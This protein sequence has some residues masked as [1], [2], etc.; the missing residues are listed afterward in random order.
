MKYKTPK[1]NQIWFGFY[2]N[3]NQILLE[4]HLLE[5]KMT[6]EHLAKSIKNFNHNK[7]IKRILKKFLVTNYTLAK[8]KVYVQLT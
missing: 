6:K 3:K 4:L 7:L 1:P 5:L 8:L 2:D